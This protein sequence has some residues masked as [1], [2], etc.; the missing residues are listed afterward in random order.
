MPLYYREIGMQ[1]VAGTRLISRFVS[2]RGCSR[3]ATRPT[4]TWASETGSR[5]R[6]KFAVEQRAEKFIK[7]AAQRR[8]GCDPV[9]SALRTVFLQRRK[10]GPLQRFVRH[11]QKPPLIRPG[12]LMRRVRVESLF[13]IVSLASGYHGLSHLPSRTIGDWAGSIEFQSALQLARMELT[14]LPVGF[15]Q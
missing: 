1:E 10:P 15:F 7:P 13:K 3:A 5:L 14:A 9:S 6:Q 12:Q 11:G 8:Q 4:V 2:G